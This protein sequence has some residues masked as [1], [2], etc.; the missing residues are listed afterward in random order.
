MYFEPIAF[1]LFSALA[2]LGA[3]F[4][5]FQKNPI[6]AA[7]GLILTLLSSAALYGLLSAGFV[8]VLQILVYAG[9]VMVLFVFVIMML[10]VQ[11]EE[12]ILRRHA[13]K[14][15]VAATLALGLAFE[16]LA[17]FQAL[18]IA[19]A[20]LPQNFGSLDRVGELL[21]SSY[22]LPFE[23]MSLLLLVALIGAV[24]SAKKHV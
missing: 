1:W 24:M 20:A 15:A 8:A 13:V 2:L 14:K 6:N 4:V 3:L 21:L 19:R 10:N 7:L 18:R 12:L 23:L 9:A 22:A 5:I 11:R 16:L 17:Q